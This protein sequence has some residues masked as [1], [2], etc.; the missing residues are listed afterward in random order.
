MLAAIRAAAE[1]GANET[2]IIRALGLPDALLADAGVL[3]KFRAEIVSGH[4]RY[5]ID[6]R[7]Q[8]RRR[9]LRT[10]NTSGSVN[11]L[12]L[13]ARNILDWDKLLPAQESEPD[14]ATARQ[15]LRDLF[16]KLAQSTSEVEGRT[17]TALELLHREA[18]RAEPEKT[19]G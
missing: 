18:Q 5:A 2:E 7:Q 4:A 19:S 8:I 12:A 10:S 16:V 9:G 11:A 17:V 3:T 14:I 1:A 13:Q 15:R 6:L